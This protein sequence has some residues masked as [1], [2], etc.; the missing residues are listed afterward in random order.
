MAIRRYDNRLEHL[1]AIAAKVFAARGFHATSMRDLARATGMSLGGMYYYVSGKDD[2]L[3][4]IQQR[5]FTAV[6]AGAEA[7]VSEGTDPAD[8][9]ERF[10]QQHVTFFAEHMSE[11]Q[12]LS[13]EAES[14]SAERQTDINRL[15]RRYVNLLLGLI[16]EATS[17]CEPE[18]DSRVAAYALFGMMNWIYTW[19]DPAGPIAPNALAD[20]F[21]ALFLHGLLTATPSSLPHGG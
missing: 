14:L 16:R 17:A 6:L 8:R 10:I 7:I 20:Q 2:L 18:R 11:M 1:L 3:F 15:K 21:S 9:L 5:S 19:Y 13:H 4:Q 12:V